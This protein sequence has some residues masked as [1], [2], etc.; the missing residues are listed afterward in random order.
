MIDFSEN[1]GVP[2]LFIYLIRTVS[3]IKIQTKFFLFRFLFFTHLILAWWL[4]CSP[5]ARETRI[6]SQV[7]SYQIFK[8]WYLMPP[9]LTFRFI[10]YESR[11]KWSNLRKEV[12]P[13]STRWCCRYRKGSLRVTLDYGRQ[14]YF[15][16]LYNFYSFQSHFVDEPYIR[17][18]S[19]PGP[20]VLYLWS[21]R[22][23]TPWKYLTQ[24][25]IIC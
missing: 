17:L 20:Y 2:I 15:S 10:R 1:F 22:R 9:C 24:N 8:K 18:V 25:G 12:A 6:Q 3:I 11:V 4:E 19:S 5:M 16:Y 23:K 7:E 13:S 14:L 21:R